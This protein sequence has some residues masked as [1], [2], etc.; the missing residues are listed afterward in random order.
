MRAIFVNHCHPDCP[1]VCGT[2]A[3]EFAKALARQGHRIVLLTETLRRDDPALEPAL[4]PAAL[5]AHDWSTPFYLAVAPLPS[6]ILE[7]VRAGRLPA[8]VRMPVIGCQYLIRGGMFSD[9]SRASRRYWKLLAEIFRPDVVWGVFGNTDAWLIAQGIAREAGCPWVRDIKDRWCG[10][11]PAPLRSVLARRFADAAGTTSLARSLLDDAQPWLGGAGAVIYSGLP[12]DL[13]RPLRPTGRA[14]TVSL[15]GGIYRPEFLEIFVGGVAG[16]QALGHDVRLVYVGTESAVVAAA[17]QRH[18]LVAEIRGQLP[19]DEYWHAI[20]GSDV[21][22]YIRVEGPA[23]HHKIVE[24]LAAQRPILCC[25]GEI[26]EARELARSTGAVYRD[27]ASPQEVRDVLDLLV[28]TPQAPR[29]EESV[30]RTL[31]WGTRARQLAATLQA[32]ARRRD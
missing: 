20:A 9:W 13:P 10:F 19:W 22:A 3:R 24:L 23:W 30:V 21:N 7:A 27:A 31:T 18:G 11:I 4:L 2:R 32:A 5:A 12:E 6:P 29:P 17:A 25:P 16:Y 14:L 28:R 1:H 26:G 8:A 15:I